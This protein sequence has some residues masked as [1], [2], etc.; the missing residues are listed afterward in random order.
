MAATGTCRRSSVVAFRVMTRQ[1]RATL[2]KDR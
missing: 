1:G 2:T